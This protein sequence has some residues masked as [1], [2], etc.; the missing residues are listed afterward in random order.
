MGDGHACP[1]LSVSMKVDNDTDWVT[2]M[3]KQQSGFTLIELVLV[4][5]I[6][7]ILAATALPRFSDLSSNARAAAVEG[8]GGS[9]RSAASIAH[10]THLAKRLSA[11]A[12]G[13]PIDGSTITFSNGYPNAATI[14]D[15]LTDFTGFSFSAPAAV[16]TF[17]KTGATGACT[18]VYNES[19]GGAYPVITVTSASC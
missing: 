2:Y 1:S 11:N 12:T 17:T 3:N 10:A 9:V 14:D 8:L 4:I 15:M 6:L 19:V 7:G 16:A 5:V 18:V 13:I